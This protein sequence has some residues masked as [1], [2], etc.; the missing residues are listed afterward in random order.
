MY[1]EAVEGEEMGGGRSR[2]KKKEEAMVTKGQLQARL[3]R[4]DLD[5]SVQEDAT[6]LAEFVSLRV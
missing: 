4:I 2:G 1:I 3:L 5:L 6:N